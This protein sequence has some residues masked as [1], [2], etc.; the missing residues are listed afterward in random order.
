MRTV[1]PNAPDFMSNL[2]AAFQSR[3]SEPVEE[4]RAEAVLLKLAD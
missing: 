3:H 2:N 4:G 1:A